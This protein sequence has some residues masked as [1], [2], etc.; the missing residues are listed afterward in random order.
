[1]KHMHPVLYRTLG[2]VLHR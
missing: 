1:M 2:T